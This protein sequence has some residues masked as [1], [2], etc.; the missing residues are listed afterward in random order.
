M[1]EL[2]SFGHKTVIGIKFH[3]RTP[4]VSIGMTQDV[5]RT[6]NDIQSQDGEKREY[7]RENAPE[8]ER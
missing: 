5:M 4:Y 6:Q 2:V 1:I 3:G 7:K 8:E